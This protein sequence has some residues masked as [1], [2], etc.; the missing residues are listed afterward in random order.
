MNSTRATLTVLTGRRFAC[1]KI[2]GRANFNTS[3]TFKALLA[4]LERLDFPCVVLDLSDCALMDSTFLGVLAGFGLRAVSQRDSGKPRVI[5]LLNAG[6]PLMESLET[7]GLLPLFQTK[8]GA[9]PAGEVVETTGPSACQPSREEITRA[10]LEAHR[11]LMSLSP[12]NAARFQ[13]VARFLAEDLQKLRK[14][15]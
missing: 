10:S 3:V 4:E 11:T 6:E 9:P 5:E 12:E 1:V 8:Q 2:T 14:A 15:E 7:M 13:D